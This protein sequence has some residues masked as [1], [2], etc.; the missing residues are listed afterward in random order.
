ML[1]VYNGFLIVTGRYDNTP[2][3]M[4]AFKN[5]VS[6]VL[7]LND[8]TQ[9]LFGLDSQAYNLYSVN[10][11][12]RNLKTQFTASKKIGVEVAPS[13]HIKIYTDIIKPVNFGNQNLQIL[14]ILPFGESKNHERKINELC[15]RR[16]N[17]SDIKNI[18]III[19]DSGNRIL[20][21]YTEHVILS[22]HFR[23]RT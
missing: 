21:N 2:K 8:N 12:A 20:E 10:S 7:V 15:Y 18:S 3:T 6:I 13:P 19:H 22:L 9:N 1:N 4:G 11:N 14:D 17:T 16:V 5:I 23:K